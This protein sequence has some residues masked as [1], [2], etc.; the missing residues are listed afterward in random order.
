MFNK[1]G[2]E[3]LDVRSEEASYKLSAF[4]LEKK[5]SIPNFLFH[6]GNNGEIKARKLDKGVVQI[7][8]NNVELNQENKKDFD[9]FDSLNVFSGVFIGSSQRALDIA[10]KCGLEIGA[11][12]S[13][14]IENGE[15]NKTRKI[16]IFRH[17]RLDTI[18]PF[19]GRRNSNGYE[20][21]FQ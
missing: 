3:G 21:H 20:F 8:W 14:T 6:A 15:G 13:F 4:L 12:F 5:W 18:Y 11:E 2:A 10:A 1:L 17:E 9:D 19:K 7:E 16:L